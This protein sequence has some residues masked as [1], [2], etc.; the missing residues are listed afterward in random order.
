ML[1]G[2][3]FR[4][5]CLNLCRSAYRNVVTKDITPNWYP[6]THRI[7]WIADGIVHAVGLLL[8]LI[9][10][11]WMLT[12]AFAQGGVALFLALTIYAVCLLAMLACSAL[13][14]ANRNMERS[15]LY[16]RIDLAGIY[17]MIA[18]TYTPLGVHEATRR[19]GQSLC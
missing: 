2:A 18:G 1:Y 4:S 19:N 14:N 11:T 3:T 5:V 12:V 17:L 16:A 10:I 6:H 13:Y 8:A 9:G 7:E 15:E